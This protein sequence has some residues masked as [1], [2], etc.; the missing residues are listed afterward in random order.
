M[1][2]AVSDLTKKGERGDSVMQ[3]AAVAVQGWWWIGLRVARKCAA[4][5][6]GLNSHPDVY[7]RCCLDCCQKKHQPRPL[8]D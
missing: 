6:L 1:R 7:P 5:Q 8:Y 4:L 3:M 2:L